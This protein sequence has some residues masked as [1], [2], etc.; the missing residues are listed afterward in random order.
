MSIEILVSGLG[1]E[2]D[3]AERSNGKGVEPPWCES[4]EVAYCKSVTRCCV[5]FQCMV[6][7]RASYENSFTAPVM[8][9]V[10]FLE[11]NIHGNSSGMEKSSLCF[12]VMRH[13][14]WTIKLNFL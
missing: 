8:D 4:E 1:E 13:K 7:A 12:Y 10:S 3:V 14:R 5:L 11:S 2:S 6:N 9:R